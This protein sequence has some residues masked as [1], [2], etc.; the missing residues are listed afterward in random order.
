MLPFRTSIRRTAGTVLVLNGRILLCKPTNGFGGYAWT[1]PKGGMDRFETP[2]QT[3]ARETLEE[4]GYP[5]RLI[6]RVPGY[7][8]SDKSAC[9]YYIAVPTGKQRIYDRAETEAT[10]WF[11]PKSAAEALS[12]SPNIA[13][14]NRDLL[15]LR[16][17]C[18]LL[19][20]QL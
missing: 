13:G 11:D 14:R 9:I 1:F 5:C 17:A 15:V 2:E 3:A 16:E 10:E 7:Y 20:L 12:K 6:K 18:K 19:G 4:S 8:L